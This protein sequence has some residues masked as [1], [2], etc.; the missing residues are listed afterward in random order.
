MST[1]ERKTD[2]QETTNVAACV[3]V[4]SG[5]SPRTIFGRA[6]SGDLVH[7]DQ[8]EPGQHL[9]CPDCRGE[10]IAVRGAVRVHHFRHSADAE[11]RTAGETAIHQ[12]AKKI[13]LGG[14]GLRI[15]DFVVR[16]EI[17]GARETVREARDVT[18]QQVE[19]EVFEAGLRPDLIGIMESSDGETVV[20]RRLIIE[21]RVT[22]PVGAEKL[23]RLAERG[24][25]VLEIDLSRVDRSLTEQELSE[26]VLQEAPRT[27][28]FHREEEEAT[29]Q[30]RK[31]ALAMAREKD[32]RRERAKAAEAR[33]EDQR[34]SAVKRIPRGA[35]PELLN[36]AKSDRRRWYLLHMDVL[37]DGVRGSGIFDV[38]HDVWVARIFSFLAP[39]KPERDVAPSSHETERR[40]KVLARKLESAGWVKPEFRGS[41]KIW[42]DGRSREWDP[43]AATIETAWKERLTA[44]GYDGGSMSRE[45]MA[46]AARDTK[47]AWQDLRNLRSGIMNFARSLELTDMTLRLHGE[48]PTGENFHLLFATQPPDRHQMWAAIRSTYDL[49]DEGKTIET[50][51]KVAQGLER[52]GF[53]ITGEGV[54]DTA[55]ACLK[56]RNEWQGRREKSLT[57]FITAKAH[58]V[59]SVFRDLGDRAQEVYWV[60]AARAPQYLD[61]AWIQSQLETSLP[62]EGWQPV[63]R[64]EKEVVAKLEPL[65]A[66][67]S[68]LEQVVALAETS[69]FS[70]VHE[71]ISH[72][73]AEMVMDRLSAGERPALRGTRYSSA[74]AEAQR[75]IAELEGMEERRGLPDLTVRVLRS[76]PREANATFLDCL[77]TYESVSFRRALADLRG[78]KPPAWLS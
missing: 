4:F 18:F 25:S 24:E 17:F 8:A 51:G 15:P 54:E 13:I 77:L 70:G 11:C 78:K 7:V 27:W 12:L 22:H 35:S 74:A 16:D 28:L 50:H 14:K 69:R 40:A 49:M 2:K 71:L 53:T 64:A 29:R 6:A 67:S 38:E 58:D 68:A 52:A 55:A 26:L 23:A 43:V 36:S 37:F 57:D 60:V 48:V 46:A 20:R 41:L 62:E 31:R 44:L 10:L 30:L 75:A 39:W 56:F 65:Q 42:K 72:R 66:V 19:E 33:R 34:A 47:D 76:V 21:I 32:Q 5:S 45:D 73:G 59:L 3:F 61:V 9:V 63:E 1:P